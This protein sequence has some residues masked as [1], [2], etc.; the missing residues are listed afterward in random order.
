MSSIIQRLDKRTGITYV[1]ESTSY[2]DKE[3]K[4]P[5]SKRVLIGK[6]DSDTG[7]IVPTDGRG[8]R[9][10]ER[11]HN[12]SS[13]VPVKQGPVPAIRTER[14]F[15]GA[16]YLFD[17]IG[18]ITGVQ[19]DL[20]ACFPDN[21]K[22]ILSISYYLI[23]EDENPLY[24]FSKWS[25]LHRHPYGKDISSQRSS[26]IFQSITEEQKMKFF[27]L[28]GERRAEK[29]YW[30]YDTTSIS[31]Y[32]E[33]LNQV[34]YG[35]NKDHEHLPQINLA[36]LFGEESGLP[37]YY[38]KLAGNIPDI[39]TIRELIRELDVLGYRKA[40]LSMD[41]GFCSADNINALYK[42]HYKFLLGASTTLK[43][44]KDFIGE[45][46]DAKDHFEFYNSDFDLYV[47]SKTIAWDYEQQRPYKGDTIREDRRMYLHLY[48]N[49]EKQVDDAKNFNRRMI[50]YREE[51]LSGHRV[52]EHE[53]QYRKYFEIKE[54]PKRGIS[55][56][57]RQ[58]KI[59]AARKRYGFFTL[60]SNEVKD[61][62]TALK[63]YRMRDVAE[64]AFWNI[65]D[66]L[67]LRRTLT[68]SESSLEGKLFVEFVALIYLSY[69][70]KKMEEEHL[71]SKYT[72]HELLDELDV[73]ECFLEPGKAPIQGEVL[74]KQEQLYRDL[75]V[76]P[77]LAHPEQQ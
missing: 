52:P 16:T 60:I 29:E 45:V 15:Y 64:K 65:K 69:I 7:K 75:G 54:T 73:I 31:S 6:V 10:K 76:K 9:R 30:A 24:R 8:N 25:K 57:Y 55:V 20:K 70:N 19:A 77:L 2:W 3:K 58:D 14:V 50:Q 47:F 4:Q 74:M 62:V 22:Q 67:N 66:R 63:L 39:K 27:R 44:A 56:T 59:D 53:A 35:K 42:D 26:E 49:P 11:L 33:T 46:G 1:Y 37:F 72:M 40:K 21:Y 68:S 23:L 36:I 5:R 71:Y 32:S 12:E 28:Q 17:Q 41:R 38:R 51:I 13:V 34:K 48:Y 61:P 43:Y 18:E